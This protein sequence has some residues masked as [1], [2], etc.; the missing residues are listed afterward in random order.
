VSYYQ[1]ESEVTKKVTLAAV[2]KTS[3]GMTEHQSHRYKKH[4]SNYQRIPAGFKT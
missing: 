2:L 1:T 4:K 3:V